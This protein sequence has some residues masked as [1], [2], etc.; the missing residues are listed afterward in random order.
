MR[1][2][3]KALFSFCFLLIVS[4]GFLF[5]PA[6]SFHYRE[7]WQFLF[8]FFFPIFLGGIILFLRNRNLLA[9][10]LQRKE[11]DAWQQKNSNQMGMLFNL[12]LILAGLDYRWKISSIPWQART[13]AG[14][15]MAAS[16]LIYIWTAMSNPYLSRV[17]EI[18]DGQR[19][20]DTGPYSCT[21]HPMYTG[22]ILLFIA[23]P[24]VLN[25]Y[26]ALPAFIMTVPFFVRRLLQEELML[27]NELPGYREYEERVRY[28]LFP[29]I[30]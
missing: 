27:E 25:S 2:L 18:R 17:V 5:L 8:L 7:A 16:Y 6:G 26:M 23:I 15:V 20:V 11:K 19:L 24:I 10:R 28:R 29:G 12:G 9:A 4:A 3:G 1:L 13:A 30:W 14:I 21:R 22:S